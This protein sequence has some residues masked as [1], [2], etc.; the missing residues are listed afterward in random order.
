MGFDTV[1]VA[2][3]SPVVPTIFSNDIQ[4]FRKLLWAVFATNLLPNLRWSYSSSLK[5]AID[6]DQKSPDLYLGCKGDRRPL[7]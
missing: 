3:S 2:G 5:I 7:R 1:E 4:R 6:T